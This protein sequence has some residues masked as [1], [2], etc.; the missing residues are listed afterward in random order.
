[1]SRSALH[2]RRIFL[3]FLRRTT[4]NTNKRAKWDHSP[5]PVA[6]GLRLCKWTTALV[7]SF[8]DL[9]SHAQLRCVSQYLNTIAALPQSFPPQLTFGAGLTDQSAGSAGVRHLRPSA[10]DLRAC[11]KLTV[12]GLGFLRHLP[13]RSLSVVLRSKTEAFDIRMLTATQTQLRTLDIADSRSDASPE[14]TASLLEW[15]SGCTG[16]RRLKLMAWHLDSPNT[17]C[18]LSKL[19]NLLHL[20][21][22]NN[23][24]ITSASLVPLR[25]M[26]LHSLNLRNTRVDEECVDDLALIILNSSE[27]IVLQSVSINVA[28]TTY[29]LFV[30]P[31]SDEAW[32][33]TFHGRRCAPIVALRPWRLPARMRNWS[34]NK[35]HPRWDCRSPFANCILPEHACATKLWH[36]SAP[37]RAFSLSSLRPCLSSA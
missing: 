13:L 5:T 31:R 22:S 24:S 18:P 35:Q 27:S 23:D 1:M 7:F 36:C 21:L 14:T 9:H 28:A 3:V 26:H 29:V 16:L 17:V 11:T 20:D 34:A 6:S 12:N 19:P 4:A 15:I 30:Q 37:H 2:C 8:L 32:R 33:W 25:S 10:L